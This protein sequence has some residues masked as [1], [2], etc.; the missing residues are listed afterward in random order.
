MRILLC[1]GIMTFCISSAFTRELDKFELFGG[2]SFYHIKDTTSHGWNTAATYHW[3]R[4]LGFSL[5]IDGFYKSTSHVT[6][7][8]LTFDFSYS[9]YDYLIGPSFTPKQL[10][11]VT[12]FIHL[13]AGVRHSVQ[14]SSYPGQLSSLSFVTNSGEIILV[15]GIIAGPN[16]P[17]TETK[18][19]VNKLSMAAGGG[20]DIRIS[21][22]IS[23]RAFQADFTYKAASLVQGQQPPTK[24]FRF[25][26]GIVFN[27]GGK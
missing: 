13:L 7:T 11:R 9:T 23:I 19:S 15:P 6:P 12:P 1:F 10:G 27:F 18:Y 17:S 26:S 21:K 2:Y 14:H 8:N 22:H 24:G 16:M 25:S 5:D 3:N 20:A 4:W